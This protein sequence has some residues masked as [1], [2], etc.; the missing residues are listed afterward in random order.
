MAQQ[1]IDIIIMDVNL[2]GQSGLELAESLREQNNIGL[3][4]LTAATAMTTVY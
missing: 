2:P 3:V 4:F 1:Q